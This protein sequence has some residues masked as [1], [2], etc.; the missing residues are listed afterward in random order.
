MKLEKNGSTL[1]VSFVGE[2]VF[3]KS[4]AIKESIKE[5]IS[6]DIEKIII[7]M[8]KV[9][10]IDSS[11]LGILI[12]LLR[13]MTEKNGSIELTNLPNLVKRLLVITKLNTLF[14]IS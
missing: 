9:T 14:E 13:I 1:Y 4:N 10:L 12:S 6:E 11:G 3:E 7:D 5:R 8:S 2:I